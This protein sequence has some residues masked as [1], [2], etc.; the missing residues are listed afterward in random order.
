MLRRTLSRL[1]QAHARRSGVRAFAA[2]PSPDG[3]FRRPEVKE[4]DKE[5]TLEDELWYADAQYPERAFDEGEIPLWQL[6]ARMAVPFS[7][8]FGLYKLYEHNDPQTHPACPG[9]EGNVIM[10]REDYEAN[11]HRF[12]PPKGYNTYN[13][14][15]PNSIV[16][17]PAEPAAAPAEE[18]DDE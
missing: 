10:Y 15:Y 2:G 17:K 18:E 11:R 12:G 14:A 1:A 7:L 5:I 13:F 3:I 4:N 9:K 16:A 6:L 8:L